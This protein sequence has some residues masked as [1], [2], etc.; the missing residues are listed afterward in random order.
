MRET[1]LSGLEGGVASNAI[2]TPIL[3]SPTAAANKR[4]KKAWIS[5]GL[6]GK[7]GP[8]RITTKSRQGRTCDVDTI[9]HTGLAETVLAV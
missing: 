4:I 3:P 7:S 8:R 6:F 1:R 9:L 5:P 2:P